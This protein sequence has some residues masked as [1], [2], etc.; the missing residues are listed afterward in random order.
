M[1][2]FT[3]II[4]I[5]LITTLTGYLT[6]LKSTRED[7]NPENIEKEK[8]IKAKYESLLD[9]G[10]TLVSVCRGDK[11]FYILTDKR[12]FIENKKG[13]FAIDLDNIKK[14]KTQ[15]MSG[16]KVSTAASCMRIIIKADKNYSLYRQSNNFTDI[17]QFFLRRY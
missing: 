9:D 14:V 6:T 17:A 8:K 11:G 15:N 10:E 12:L 2:S 4:I 3:I 1:N 7:N 13:N 16:G 5:G